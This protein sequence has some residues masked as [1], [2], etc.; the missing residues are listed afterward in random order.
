[1][2]Q[3][4]DRILLHLK[5]VAEERRLRRRLPALDRKTT[6]LKSYQQQRLAR[7]YADLLATTDYGPAARFFLD[8]LYG[9]S[10]FTRRDEQF[11]RIVPALVRLFPSSLTATVASLAELHALSEHLDT[12]MAQALSSDDVTDE[13]YA[14]A[15]ASVGDCKGRE[16]QISLTMAIGQALE[17]HTAQPLVRLTLHAMRR[18]ASLAGLGDLQRFLEAGFDSFHRMPDCSWF[19]RQIAEREGELIRRLF[20]GDATCLRGP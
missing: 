8:D 3:S 16:R 1:M 12:R 10:D 18:P 7:T 15:W 6:A 9:P 2:E 5:A 11:E 4:G 14:A 20:A 19:L 13:T 17:R